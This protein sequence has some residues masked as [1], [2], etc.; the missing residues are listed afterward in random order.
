MTEPLVFVLGRIY[1]TIADELAVTKTGA[2]GHNGVV[3]A[4][5][6]VIGEK[7]DQPFTF[8]ALYWKR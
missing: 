5:I 2:G 6:Y 4:C 3:A 8:F 1:K 7:S